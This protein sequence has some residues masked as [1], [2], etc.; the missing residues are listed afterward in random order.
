MFTHE[1][2]RR[3]WG[4]IFFVMIVLA[5]SLVLGAGQASN[6][7]ADSSKTKG[8]PA[9]SSRVHVFRKVGLCQVEVA[10]KEFGKTPASSSDTLSPMNKGNAVNLAVNITNK[11]DVQKFEVQFDT[12][13][14]EVTDGAQI[15][16]VTVAPKSTETFR[17]GVRGKATQKDCGSLPRSLQVWVRDSNNPKHRLC[18]KAL[19]YFPC[20]TR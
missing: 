16:E 9:D 11:G 5:T 4:T 6:S 10:I 20:A 8:K 18:G 17:L 7:K 15:R 3:Q 14:V 1:N 19:K 12:S 13:G 2:M